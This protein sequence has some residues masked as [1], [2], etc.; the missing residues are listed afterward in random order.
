MFLSHIFTQ[1]DDELARRKRSSIPTRKNTIAITGDRPYLE[2]KG[3]RQA[4][5]QRRARLATQKKQGNIN[6]YLPNNVHTRAIHSPASEQQQRQPTNITTTSG[7]EKSRLR[8]RPR[9]QPRRLVESNRHRH[10]DSRQRAHLLR[11]EHAALCAFA[12]ESRERY[13]RQGEEE[14]QEEAEKWDEEHWEWGEELRHRRAARGDCRGA[15][16]G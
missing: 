8:K 12:T 10:S 13:A 7:N 15:R 16:E 3:G 11:A 5:R 6:P 1:H 9:P 4:S 2:L 14:G